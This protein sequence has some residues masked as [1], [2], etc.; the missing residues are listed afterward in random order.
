MSSART[1]FAGTPRFRIRERLGAGGMGLVYR[2]HDCEL[3][4]DGKR[5]RAIELLRESITGFEDTAQYLNAN[6]A[7]MRLGEMLGGDE[8]AELIEQSLDWF[9][10]QNVDDPVRLAHAMAPGFPEPEAEAH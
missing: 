4:I 7:R 6:A 10:H 2:A 1:G 8:G 3:G 5:E 9:E